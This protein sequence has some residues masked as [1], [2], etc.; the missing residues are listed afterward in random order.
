MS[1]VY[2]L[3]IHLYHFIIRIV[4]P[5]NP[6]ARLWVDGRKGIFKELTEQLDPKDKIAWFHAASLGEFE[7]GRPIIETFRKQYPDY[8]I[9]LTFFSPSGYE[10]RKDYEGADYIVYLPIDTKK[11][12]RK[13]IRIVQPKLVI[14][15]KYEFWFNYLRI[16]SENN[17]PVFFASVIFRKEQHFFQWYGAWSRKMLKKVSFFFVQNKASSDLLKSIGIRQVLM[18]GDTRFDRVFSIA[19]NAK[20]FPLVEKFAKGDKVFLAGSTWPADEEI[21]EKMILKNPSLKLIIAPHEI[22]QERIN[23]LIKKF[24]SHKILK[25]SETNEENISKAQILIIDGMGFLSGLYQYCDIAY[26]GGGFGKGIHNILEAATFG[27]PV[28]FGPNYQRFA[29]AVELVQLKGAFAIGSSFEVISIT[30]TLK[31]NEASWQSA[32]SICKEYVLKKKGATEII[33]SKV[34]EFIS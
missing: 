31:N 22:H 13:F 1:F 29:E 16:L 3:F 23:S 33:L 9:L 32:S 27:K 19:Q 20:K 12:A 26:I 24:A 8:K 2:S 21:I 25:Y 4:A 14:F 11:N 7:Q 28:I 34:S 17:I 30:D 18:S 5:F 15:I 6:K 10:I